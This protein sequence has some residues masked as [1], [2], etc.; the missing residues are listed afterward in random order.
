LCL[1]AAEGA[2]YVEQEVTE[3]TVVDAD[4]CETTVTT[5]ET[6]AVD[7]E[8]NYVV[9]TEETVEYSE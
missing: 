9:A 8:G 3:E 6:T 1:A 7:D 4:G 5:V 2:V